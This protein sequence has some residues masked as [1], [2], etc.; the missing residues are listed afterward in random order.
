MMKFEEFKKAAFDA[1][2]DNGCT[3][4]EV[5][6]TDEEQFSVNVQKGEIEDYS[7]AHSFGL[8]LRVQLDGK[9]GYAYT[10]LLEDPARLV[11]KAMDNA[12]AIE[13]TDDHPMQPACEYQTVTPPECRAMD[14]TAEEKIA[15]VKKLEKALFEADNRVL[16]SEET[17]IGTATVTKRLHNTLGLAADSTRKI[18]YSVIVPIMQQGEEIKNSV[19]FRTGNEVFNID[20]IVKE[21]VDLAN[22]QFNADP[23]PSGEYKVLLRSDAASSMLAGFSGMFSADACQKGLSLLADKL[24]QRIASEVVTILDDPFYYKNPRA[25]DDE[26]VPSVTKKV[27]DRG[28][29]TTFLH[30]LKTAKKAGVASTSNAGRSS[31][32]P[33]GVAPS[34]FYITEGEKSYDELVRELD[35]GVIITEVKGLHSGLNAISGD[36]SLQANGL[37]VENGRIVRNVGRI[38]VA[39]NFIKL[40]HNIIAVGSDL[41]WGFPM[42]PNVGSP[43]LLV[44]KLVISG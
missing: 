6:L 18:A 21:G 38:T 1:A 16:R 9:N 44:E 36:F 41:R 26:G 22:E 20:E 12:K 43:S 3:A 32:G 28:E 4:A 34:N 19:A 25:F 42:G 11:M 35:N 15:Y 30:N 29:L 27:V 23:V 5:L 17:M 2:L 39:G 10:E 13:S 8:N 37:L 14:M 40:M 7:S 33:V 31:A 24:G